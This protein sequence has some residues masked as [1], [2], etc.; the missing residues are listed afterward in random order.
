MASER[1]QR[2]IKRLLD[3]IEDAADARDWRKV[4]QLAED[5]LLADS[6]TMDAINFRAMAQRQ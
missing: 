3:Q 2:R 6:G 4:L 5:V 1:F